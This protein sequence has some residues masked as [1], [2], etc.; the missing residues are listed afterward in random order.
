MM[1]SQLNAQPLAASTSS[2][3]LNFTAV[4]QVMLSASSKVSDLIFS[5]GRPPQIEL[6]GRTGR[7]HAFHICD[8]KT[9]TTDLL[10]DRGLMGEGCINIREISNWVDAAGFKG[11]R[12]V[13]I[14][15]NHWWAEDQN[16]FLDAIQ[17]SYT[18]LYEADVPIATT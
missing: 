17:K 7:L 2:S 10:N 9:P 6:A 5:P 3:P 8:W 12:E 4:L 15:S 18:E 1:D 13:E 11:H 14:F 16:T